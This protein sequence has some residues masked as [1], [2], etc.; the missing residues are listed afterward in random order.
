MITYA[1]YREAEDA[2]NGDF[3]ANE[4]GTCGDELRTDQEREVG[5]CRECARERVRREDE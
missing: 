5:E 1:P 2:Y 4:C 3:W